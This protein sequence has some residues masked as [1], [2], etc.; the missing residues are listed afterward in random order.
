MFNLMLKIRQF[1]NLTEYTSKLDL[2]LAAFD[3]AHP[4]S[5]ASQRAEKK[6]YDRIYQLRDR[7]TETSQPKNTLWE[8]F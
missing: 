1:L 7:K 4:R 2:F 6:K 3:K 8:K 5:S